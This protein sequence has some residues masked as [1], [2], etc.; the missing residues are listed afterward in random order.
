MWQTHLTPDKRT[1]TAPPQFVYSRALEK[2][3]SD[4]LVVQGQFCPKGQNVSAG[5]AFQLFNYEKQFLIELFCAFS[6]NVFR[7]RQN[8]SIFA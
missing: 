8:V 4:S 6:H 3:V 5:R 7:K 2:A 1:A